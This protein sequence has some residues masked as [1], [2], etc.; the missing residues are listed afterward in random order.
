MS[1]LFNLSIYNFRKR[2]SDGFTTSQEREQGPEAADDWLATIG[3]MEKW[4]LRLDGPEGPQG[5]QS[6]RDRRVYAVANNIVEEPA[7][8]WWVANVLRRR[9]QIVSKLMGDDSQVRDH[10]E[11]GTDG[12]S[13]SRFKSLERRNA[14][15]SSEREATCWIPGNWLS[16][17]F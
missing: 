4:K 16:Y 1:M 5:V 13:K 14:G 12:K 2:I 17:D 9:N 7:F 8:K 11:M 15:G 3:R 10:L 6:G